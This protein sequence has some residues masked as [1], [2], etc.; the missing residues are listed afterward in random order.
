MSTQKQ[1]AL[2]EF[3]LRKIAKGKFN[4]A[5]TLALTSLEED[6]EEGTLEGCMN[7]F[8]SAWKNLEVAANNED[9]SNPEDEE[10][11]NASLG[12]YME[13]TN[14]YSVWKKGKDA[15]KQAKHEADR[16]AQQEAA[17]QKRKAEQEAEDQKRKAEQEAVR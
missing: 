15:E 10:Y 6:E 9:E 12:D 7:D 3:N 16:K 13:V 5:R 14:R 2:A 8:Q 11:I 4:R 1:K 17:D